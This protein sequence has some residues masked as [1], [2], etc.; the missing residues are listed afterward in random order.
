MLSI[1]GQRHTELK[2]RWKDD[3]NDD[4]GDHA[5]WHEGRGGR[6]WVWGRG[7]GGWID[8]VKDVQ[9]LFAELTGGLLY[10]YKDPY[11]NKVPFNHNGFSPGIV[12]SLGWRFTPMLSTQLNFLGTN[13]VMFQISA[14]IK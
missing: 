13:A 4:I 10:G 5:E 7:R 6:F 14:D 2:P 12:L 1:G 11:E 8:F 3:L 9:P